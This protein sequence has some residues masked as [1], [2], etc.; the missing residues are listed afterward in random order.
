MHREAAA[1]VSPD[2]WHSGL[3]TGVLLVL[4]SS[5]PALAQSVS[6][7]VISV[8]DGD[9]IRM[10]AGRSVKTIRLACIDTPETAQSPY[11]AAA[12]QQ[13]QSLLPTG[14]AIQVKVKAT[15]RYGRSVGEITR[16]GHNINQA[17]VGSGAAFVYWQYIQGCDRQTYSRLEND[18]RLKAAGVWSVKGGI[19]RPWDYRSGRSG[20]SGSTSATTPSS[21]GSSSRKYRC[22]DFKTAAEAQAALKQGH[23]YLDKDGDGH[24]CESLR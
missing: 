19:T 5:P 23:S 4:W 20:S 17:L 8:G 14:S 15:D 1:L 11:G 2:A 7:S 21:Q 18:A 13:L 16:N 10:Q 6:G 9:T 24:A 22:S 3:L 12:R